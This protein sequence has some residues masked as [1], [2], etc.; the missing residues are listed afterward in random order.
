M[1]ATVSAT[2]P[3]R[4]LLNPHRRRPHWPRVVRPDISL[5]ARDHLRCRVNCRSD[6]FRRTVSVAAFLLFI[7]C[8][9]FPTWFCS[10]PASATAF[11]RAVRGPGVRCAYTHDV[12]PGVFMA[13][14][15]RRYSIGVTAPW[16]I[17]ALIRRPGFAHSR[18]FVAWNLLGL[19]DL[20]VAV[21]IGTLVAAFPTASRM[22]QRGLA[23]APAAH[24]GFGAAVRH[25]AS[26]R[27]LQARRLATSRA[28][29]LSRSA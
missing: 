25:P 14:W 13:G 6:P 23:P 5:G 29:E 21:S 9:A 11:R 10:R 17:V 27:A 1:S 18:A 16:V 19:L 12:L 22:R 20:A 7:G 8:R 2:T 3:A 26:D 4:A 15:S 28:A 24:P